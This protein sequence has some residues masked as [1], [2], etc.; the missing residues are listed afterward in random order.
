ME[1]AVIDD[2][3]LEE[4]AQE[5]SEMTQEDEFDEFNWYNEHGI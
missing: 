3:I 1:Q 5:A 2:V 4:V